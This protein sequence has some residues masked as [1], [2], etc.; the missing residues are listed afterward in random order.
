[1]DHVWN[2]WLMAAL[3]LFMP[4]LA[5][6]AVQ[7]ILITQMTPENETATVRQ[8]LPRD[9]ASDY[10]RTTVVCCFCIFQGTSAIA[11]DKGWICPK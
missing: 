5:A 9:A 8:Y 11:S 1:M 2:K 4:C 10:A 6:H 3:L 7:G